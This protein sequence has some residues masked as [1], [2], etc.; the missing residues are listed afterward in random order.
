MFVVIALGGNALLKRGEPLT[1]ENQRANVR[2]A[3]VA[4]AAA[5][6]GGHRV[7]ICHGNGPQVGLLALQSAAYKSD[8]AYPLDVLGAETEGMIGY[9]IEQELENALPD[10]P[11]VATLLT[12]V[13]VDPGD[14]A[15][16]K[17]TKPI[18]PVFDRQEAEHLAE[19]RGWAIG[20]DGEKYRR[21]VASPLPKHI[22]DVSI[23]RL[24]ADQDV[25][26][27]CAGG[28]GH[29]RRDQ[30]DRRS[31]RRAISLQRLEGS[32]LQQDVAGCVPSGNEVLLALGLVRP[33]EAWPATILAIVKEKGS[34]RE[35][36]VSFHQV[37][38]PPSYYSL[39]LGDL[40]SRGL[41]L[42]VY[43]R[44]GQDARTEPPGEA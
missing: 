20:P 40:S 31:R 23:I 14:R 2:R 28:G 8:E 17:P 34:R 11:R 24:L 25:I 6:R 26:V 35:Q 41:A 18:G 13:L 30:W 19:A 15:F 22:P 12:Q 37:W 44:P 32:P 3:A 43:Q 10:G 7:V 5:V 33:G 27:I 38:L 9:L 4:I 21:V 29:F 1:A 16:W 42:D 36:L 39:G